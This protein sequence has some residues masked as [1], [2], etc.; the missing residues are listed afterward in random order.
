MSGK[1]LEKEKKLDC[2]SALGLKVIPSCSES[3]TWEMRALG[4]SAKESETIESV[5]RK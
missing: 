2:L 3:I 5:G 4:S 1:F